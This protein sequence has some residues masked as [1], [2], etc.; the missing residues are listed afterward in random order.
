M[1]SDPLGP[2]QPADVQLITDLAAQDALGP[3]MQVMRHG[4]DPAYGEA[5]NHSQTRSML[6][7][8]LSH[9]IIAEAVPAS[10]DGATARGVPI[11][12]AMTRRVA[13]EEEL[14]LIAVMP[15]WRRRSVGSVLLTQVIENARQAGVSRIFLEMR[16]N[17]PAYDFYHR[18][19]FNQIG[20]RPNY[21]TGLHSQRYDALT[22]V[23]SL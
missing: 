16:A 17:N 14:L 7:M 5:W 12:F 8:P 2:D 10:Q 18:F 1:A 23:K 9:T 19:D 13:D 6:A 4:F 20:L 3:I 22:L 15:Q 11:G 21:Y